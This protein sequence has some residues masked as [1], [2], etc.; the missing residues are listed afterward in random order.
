MYTDI[1]DELLD[2]ILDKLYVQGNKVY[3][4]KDINYIELEKFINK[5][6]SS[7]DNKILHKYSNEDI[8]NQIKNIYSQYVFFYI[9]LNISTLH[10]EKS[11][12]KL[13]ISLKKTSIIL[14]K[15]LNISLVLQQILYIVKNVK[16]ITDGKIIL[17]DKYNIA[18]KIYND[19]SEIFTSNLKS[20]DI[21]HSVMKYILFQILFVKFDKSQLYII[22]E[23]YELGQLESK[24]IEIVESTTQQINYVTL[25]KL[26]SDEK[27]DETFIDDIYEMLISD[28][29]VEEIS[30]DDK[31]KL[32]F[33][34]NMLIPITDDF[35]RYNKSTEL[36]D[37]A[38]NID[39]SVKSNKKN[40]TK[41][42]YIINKINDVMDYYKNQNCKNFY[43]PLIYRKA[44]LVNNLE[45]MEI[46]RKLE[47][48]HNKTDEQIDHYEELT[49][50]RKYPYRN[51]R[52]LKSYGFSFE[53][54]E[55]IDSIRY[56]NIEYLN[57]SKYDF[58]KSNLIDWR[59]MVTES[60]SNIVGVALPCTV[61]DKSFLLG[62][63]AKLSNIENNKSS[64]F[65]N[66]MKMFKQQIIMNTSYNKI[67]YWIFDRK[68]DI[69]K[70]F[71]ELRNFP[72]DEYFKCILENIYDE[73]AELTYEKIINM[74]QI[75]K[76]TTV[77][78]VLNLIN[79]MEKQYI[80]L[81][82]DK[83]HKIYQYIFT[84]YSTQHK[85]IY[86]IGEDYIPGQKQPLQP[87]IESLTININNKPVIRDQ[88]ITNNIEIDHYENAQCQHFLS[89]NRMKHLRMKY[90]NKFNQKLHVFIKEYVMEN[91][92]KEYICKS[93]S[94]LVELKRYI[95]DWTSTTEEGINF[96]LSLQTSLENIP[97]YEKYT[98]AI[99]NMER[100]MEK[101]SASVALSYFIGS[102]P[103]A[104]IARQASIKSMIDLMNAQYDKM[105]NM[106]PIERK[107]RS[108]ES[109]KK[110]GIDSKLTQFFMFELK[111]DIFTYSSKEID[112]FKIPKFNNITA[113]ILLLLLLE[114]SSSIIQSFSDEKILNYYIFEKI[115]FDIFEGIFIRINSANDITPI[116]NYKI[117]C[118][119][120]FML[121][122]FVVKYKMWFTDSVDKKSL[123]NA[124]DQKKVIH[125]LIDI[126]NSV[127]DFNR[128]GVT[129]YVYENYSRRF[130]VK[131][132][133]IYSGEE[134]T[135][136]IKILK[137][138]I[139]G[140]ITVISTNKI[141]FKTTIERENMLK[142][143]WVKDDF[144]TYLWAKGVEPL[145]MT[146]FIQTLT[147]DNVF[148]NKE[149]EKL[150]NR[151]KFNI[152]ETKNRLVRSKKTRIIDYGYDINIL[153]SDLYEHVE[154][155]ITK[156]ES[157]IGENV[158]INNMNLYLRNNVYT[159]DHDH[160][161][162]VAP[163]TMTFID[164]DNAIIFKK[165]ELHFKTNVYYYLN[166]DKDI[167]MY[168]NSQTFNYMGYRQGKEYYAINNT[169]ANLMPIYSIK[170][171]L[172]FLGHKN[173]NYLLDKEM[174]DYVD[175]DINIVQ[176]KL[177]K[178][179][180]DIL[181]IR[182][183]N[184]KNTLINIQ[185]IVNQ[186]LTDDKKLKTEII[187][188]NFYKKFK[189][190][191]IN[192]DGIRAFDN[193]NEIINSSFF[194]KLEQDIKI[195]FAKDYIYAG[196]LIKI[197]NTDHK[198][199]MYI[200]NEFDKFL[201]I[202]ADNH[203]K[204]TLIYLFSNIIH[205]EFNI[206][207]Y[208]ES[209]MS[210]AD[211]KRFIIMDSNI[212]QKI[213]IQ[214]VD[215]FNGL[216]DDEINDLKE[217]MIDDREMMDALDIEFDSDDEDGGSAQLADTYTN[218]ADQ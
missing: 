196:N 41:L 210:L 184:L 16:N 164:S 158:R 17:D 177:R 14:S 30:Q 81:T 107:K 113:F 194:T 91:L 202:N 161:G 174:V 58:N 65:S 32:I 33:K 147:M 9:L 40:N 19:L 163:K 135:K 168:Y 109:E 190:L 55:G 60:T 86:D 197:F 51:F 218:S 117:L 205:Q 66:I 89:W 201:N 59:T 204:I 102:K 8:Q 118:Y 179:I 34:R 198:L 199:I 94:E 200:C 87:L 57:N 159:I 90:P 25:E 45:E 85:D 215:I 99:K 48:N 129:N 105:K 37:N 127:L 6:M 7:Y 47:N 180:S 82:P 156:W 151:Y 88:T 77:N 191:S 206:H 169:N 136:L 12:I 126:L 183:K 13:I 31:I 203:N 121:S 144:G 2:D 154:K 112:K 212:Y 4:Q 207:N 49:L 68:K 175:T 122:G 1:A 134:A 101:I 195:S 73:M 54:D 172:L 182:I 22:I 146:Q 93:C 131:L 176:G 21:Y 133:I 26:L 50:M 36:Y 142:D 11:F 149:Y 217:E 15:L 104:K 111:N 110:Y 18:L 62:T 213:E 3:N 167:Y 74:L 140:K 71:N 116:K 209:N 61:G 103:S 186:L 153:G 189:D 83:K 29:D 84:Q 120:I 171:K 27:Y 43:Q 23:E 70:K 173:L 165:N 64:N 157:I 56:S 145:I 211:I 98:I 39:P 69:M 166:K 216:N 130:F 148:T 119:V 63:V 193:I 78:D 137:D 79:D 52:D 114:M 28:D 170:H 20:K 42:K 10:N 128:N 187:A 178:F 188:K 95:S 132:N 143:Y 155:I 53:Y 38:T 214:E 80:T 139:D 108:I 72:Q 76:F 24:M 115:G 106:D 125:T 46:L 5:F 44:V 35:L 192:K 138:K 160:Y 162:H 150:R 92:N 67:N 152:M 141:Q 208:R 124:I 100:I 75:I 181:R 123:I 96:T 97:E 185:R